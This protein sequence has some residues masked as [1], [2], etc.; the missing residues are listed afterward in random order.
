MA[1]KETSIK[2]VKE[3]LGIDSIKIASYQRP[4]VWSE[5]N[6]RQLL[7]DVL[8]SMND[9]KLAYRIGSIILCKTS[10]NPSNYE[11]V[12]GQQR[13]TSLVLIFLAL[14]NHK[15]ASF[16]SEKQ[17]VTSGSTQ[18]KSGSE[19]QNG[20]IEEDEDINIRQILKNLEFNNSESY[21]H[22]KDNY[23]AIDI[24]IEHYLRYPEEITRFKKYLYEAC[25]FVKLV[26]DTYSEAFQMFDS[27][28]GTGKELKAYNLLKAYHIRAMELDTDDSKTECDRRWEQAT[29][30]M[31][32][33]SN[34]EIYHLDLLQQLFDEQLYRSRKWCRDE[35]ADKF[36]KKKI[37]EFKGVTINNKQKL[38]FPFQNQ[39][40]QQYIINKI[41][42]VLYSDVVNVKN[43]FISGDPKD[44]SPFVNITQDIINGR[45]FF[46]YVETYVAIYKEIFENPDGSRLHE[47]K[48]FYKK[49]CLYDNC[50]RTGDT[51]LRELYK[52]LI[53][54]LFD[55]FGEEEVNR[56]YK[57][58][59][60]WVYKLRI[61]CGSIQ[62]STA[63]NHP[64]GEGNPF[65]TICKANSYSDLFKLYQLK[66]Y[67]P[68]EGNA[69]DKKA[70][71]PN[72]TDRDQKLHEFITNGIE[73]D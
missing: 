61:K 22:I 44:I 25:T 30:F 58:L 34:G 7:N 46:D 41:Y 5:D 18:E 9:Q 17:T 35:Y 1:V 54:V 12:D 70:F 68:N 45:Q 11:I 23:K 67:S 6:I 10:D 40:L 32:K 42:N 59:Y 13:I 69:G 21:K 73:N 53:F 26:V 27:Q 24:W 36:S 16:A 31:G 71:Y 20:F 55:R 56:Y 28:N 8:D 15:K 49:Y 51:Y 57:L 37:G 62:M 33:N 43:R 63:T 39:Q 38:L 19:N 52:S 72:D 65:V 64:K 47:F 60:R 3:I 14:L 50:Y 48:K 2:P 4:Y 66:L 29:Q